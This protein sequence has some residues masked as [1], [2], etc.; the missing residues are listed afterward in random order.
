MEPSE[1]IDYR[2]GF[3]EREYVMRLGTIRLRIARTR[4]QKF[5]RVGWRSLAA[6]SRYRDADSRSLPSRDVDASSRE[7]R[8]EPVSAQTVCKLTRELDESVRQFDS[9][10]LKNEWAY[11]FLDGVSLPFAGQ[12]GA[13]ACRCWWPIWSE[14][15]SN[16]AFIS[17]P[18][19]HG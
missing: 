10:E 1:R 5:C 14:A 11:L 16:A 12:A 19:Q 7:D 18:A 4:E 15:G 3:Y 13:N 6:C 2:N 8:G 9:A 17:V